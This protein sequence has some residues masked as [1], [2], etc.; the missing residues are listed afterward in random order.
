MSSIPNAK[1]SRRAEISEPCCSAR[2]G[3]GGAQAIGSPTEAGLFNFAQRAQQPLCLER[4]AF[5][6]GRE[7]PLQQSPLAPAILGS[8]WPRPA[9]WLVRRLGVISKKELEV[10]L[11]V[12]PRIAHQRASKSRTVA[13]CGAGVVTREGTWRSN[14]PSLYWLETKKTSRFREGR[15]MHPTAAVFLTAVVFAYLTLIGLGVIPV[16]AG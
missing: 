6:A 15:A 13:R 1:A 5:G 12:G 4:P 3:R 14:R 16:T 11:S 8:D 7:P 9:F 2:G 10:P